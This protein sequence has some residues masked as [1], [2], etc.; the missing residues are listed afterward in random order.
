M[1]HAVHIEARAKSHYK[2]GVDKAKLEM[3]LKTFLLSQPTFTNGYLDVPFDL[4]N[5]V[6]SIQVCDIPCGVS[7]QVVQI[8]FFIHIYK[9]SNQEVEKEYLDGDENISA[10]LQWDL[11]HAE[12]ESLWETILVDEETIK[13]RLLGYCSS[14][15]YFATAKVN[16]TIISWNRMVLLYGPP[17]T[18]KTTLCKALSQKVFIRNELYFAHGGSLVE[19]N[20]HSLFSKWFSESGMLYLHIIYS[21][22]YS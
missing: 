13:Q 19:I 22:T 15:M 2:K 8:E 6:E 11:P 20:S 4:I 9:V 14:A 12:I 5:V 7:L 17:G 3:S 21:S 10:S 18:G 16:T 1:L